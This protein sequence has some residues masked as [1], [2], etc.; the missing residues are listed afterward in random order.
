M[1]FNEYQKIA[2]TTAHFNEEN[3]M[4][5]LMYVTMGVAGETGELVEKVKKLIRNDKGVLTEEKRAGIVAEMGDVLWY[6]SQLSALLDVPFE[7][8]AQA[9]VQKLK[10]RAARGVIKSEGDNR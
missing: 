5:K 6:L 4:Y 2:S 7:A 3:E 9:N 1:D 10:D 8:A